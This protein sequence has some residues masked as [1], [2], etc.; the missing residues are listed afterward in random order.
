MTEREA[1]VVMLRLDQ[2]Q[3][4]RIWRAARAIKDAKC[5]RAK[6]R[7]AD[8]DLRQLL[9]FYTAL[10]VLTPAEQ[11]GIYYTFSLRGI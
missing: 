9:G 11:A 6:R 7:K 8:K 3:R 5:D 10:G 4:E 2:E 1:H